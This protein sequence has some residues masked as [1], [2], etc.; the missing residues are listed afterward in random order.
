V[1]NDVLGCDS[2]F[3]RVAVQCDVPCVK[4]MEKEKQCCARTTD[5]HYG[6]VLRCPFHCTIQCEGCFPEEPMFWEGHTTATSAAK[7]S[8]GFLHEN[9]MTGGWTQT[10]KNKHGIIMLEPNILICLF[11]LLLTATVK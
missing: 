1:Y 7:R 5:E 2:L 9:S 6:E 11:T 4:T 8:L 3:S 10:L